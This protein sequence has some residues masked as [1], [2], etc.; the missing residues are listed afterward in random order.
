[1]KQKLFI[2][3]IS[4]LLTISL[5]AQKK[6][7]IEGKIEGL[8]KGAIVTLDHRAYEDYVIFDEKS[9]CEVVDGYF[10]IEGEAKPLMEESRNRSIS[11]G[12]LKIPLFRK[13]KSDGHY[14]RYW[15]RIVHPD[16]P[17]F[18]GVFISLSGREKTEIYVEGSIEMSPKEWKIESNLKD[19][20]ECNRY[21]QACYDYIRDG[22][23]LYRKVYPLSGN[24]NLSEEESSSLWVQADSINNMRYEIEM[25]M[26]N[27]KSITDFNLYLVGSLARTKDYYRLTNKKFKFDRELNQLYD[28]LTEKQKKS[29]NGILATMYLKKQNIMKENIPL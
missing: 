9:R 29:Y 1:M 17:L 5:Y 8:S 14:I 12:K 28:N 13:Y 22:H 26:S 6:Y 18:T 20:K 2:F 11:I 24:S 10:R 7:V 16:L 27:E 3:F 25:R 4:V 23:E 19:Q 21:L 15:L